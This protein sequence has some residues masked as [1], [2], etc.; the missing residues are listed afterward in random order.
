METQQIDPGTGY[1]LLEPREI[2][3]EGDEF[4]SD[5]LSSWETSGRKG[6]AAL[7][8]Y[9]SYR[10]KVKLPDPGAGYRLLAIDEVVENGDQYYSSDG[11]WHN[12]RAQ[13]SHA[14]STLTYRRKVECPIDPA[15]KDAPYPQHE[16]VKQISTKINNGL[17][18]RHVVR[19][20]RIADLRIAIRRSIEAK[21][22]VPHEW[23]AEYLELAHDD[24]MMTL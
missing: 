5:I 13:G 4:Y 11:A 10:R 17:R 16:P 3:V 15:W 7:S 18:P 14:D 6:R 1:R 9:Y 2:V 24:F 8:D 23:L 12:S 20:E 22:D 19:A 21:T